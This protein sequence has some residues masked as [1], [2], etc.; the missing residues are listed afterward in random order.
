MDCAPQAGTEE[1][2]PVGLGEPSGQEG[3]QPPG[4]RDKHGSGG[5]EGTPKQGR[6][7]DAR[8]AAGSC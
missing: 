8:Q 3:E 2:T 6:G 7:P 1:E 5:K 4:H